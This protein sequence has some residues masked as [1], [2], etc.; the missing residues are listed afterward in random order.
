MII[1]IVNSNS[2]K[3]SYKRDFGAH[4]NDLSHFLC[5]VRYACCSLLYSPFSQNLRR[6]LFS[7]R[8]YLLNSYVLKFRTVTSSKFKVSI[9]PQNDRDCTL[10]CFL[11]RASN[12]I[13][14]TQ[15]FSFRV[16]A[17]FVREITI[18]LT[19]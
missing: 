5:V 3:R 17:T 10:M 11:L 6:R 8:F 7:L 15:P 4:F 18:C 16:F 14:Y 9:L 12:C 13:S 19:G 1:L 2:V